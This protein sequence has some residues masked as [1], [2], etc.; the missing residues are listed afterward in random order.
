MGEVAGKCAE[1]ARWIKNLLML[2]FAEQTFYPRDSGARSII[3]KYY[4][5][6]IRRICKTQIKCKM[7]PLEKY[8]CL[9]RNIQLHITMNLYR[10]AIDPSNQI[11]RKTYLYILV[12]WPLL[13]QQS[14]P[15]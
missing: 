3:L 6:L 14:Q 12:P 11:F 8:I 9:D 1:I 5:F 10:L 7:K 15:D 2:D 13:Q 4:P